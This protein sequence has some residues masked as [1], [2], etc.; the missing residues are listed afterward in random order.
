MDYRSQDKELKLKSKFSFFEATE[1]ARELTFYLRWTLITEK[2]NRSSTL[3]S[4]SAFIISVILAV[5]LILDYIQY[6]IIQ[7]SLKFTQRGFILGGYGLVRP[8]NGYFQPKK[9]TPDLRGNT[10][11]VNIA[12][13]LITHAVGLCLAAFAYGSAGE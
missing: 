3:C 9:E 10:T 12:L 1:G 2:V 8:T 11:Q 6:L 5:Y 4:I 7:V 13:Y